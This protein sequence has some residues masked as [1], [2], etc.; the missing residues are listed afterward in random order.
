ME[1]TNTVVQL[2]SEQF[3]THIQSGD[4]FD[5]IVDVRSKSEW[6]SGHIEGAVFVENLHM[7]SGG[8]KVSML[9]KY[10]NAKIAV[11]CRSG[12]RSQKAAN[13]L[14]DHGFQ[15]PIYNGQGT[16]QWTE[17]G[18]PLVRSESTT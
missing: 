5:V 15:T 11:Y 3:H 13:V 1:S 6:D 18:F 10:K 14:V 9:E 17:A 7:D 12:G 2:T 4:F 16:M 8:D